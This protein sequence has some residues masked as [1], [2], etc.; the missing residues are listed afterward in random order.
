MDS[1]PGG[2]RRV[3]RI[4]YLPFP[5][6]MQLIRGARAVVFPS[7]YEGFGLPVLESMMLGTPVISSTTSS[8]PE[9]AGDAALLVNPYD[10]SAIAQAMRRLDRDDDLCFELSMRGRRQAEQFSEA[11]YQ[12]RLAE[13][14]RRM[15]I[16]SC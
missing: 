2:D 1:I 15:G 7:L 12:G 10:T 6:L 8:I 9:V 16:S 4:D 13:L 3:K 11:A 14:Y 5:M